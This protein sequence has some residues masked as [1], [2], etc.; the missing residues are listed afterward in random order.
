MDAISISQLKVNP[1]GAIGLA[2]DYPLSINN[3][4]QTTAYLIGN[5]L[6]NKIVAYLENVSDKKAVQ[7]TNFSK[8]RNFEDLANDLGI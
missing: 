6:F 5:Q 8:G 4:G 2:A 3:K 7:E 1:S